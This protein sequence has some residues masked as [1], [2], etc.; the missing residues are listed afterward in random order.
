[1]EPVDSSRRLLRTGRKRSV[2]DG[3]ASSFVRRMT[4]VVHT[5]PFALVSFDSPKT[6]LLRSRN[7]WQRIRLF[8]LMRGVRRIAYAS[9]VGVGGDRNGACQTG[10]RWRRL[11]QSRKSGDDGSHACVSSG[12]GTGSDD[13]RHSWTKWWFREC[14]WIGLRCERFHSGAL[15]WPGDP[16]KRAC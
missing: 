15:G 14:Q 7:R 2:G 16:G 13:G 10:C 4:A 8:P 11:G 6:P 5:H 12:C 9:A 1:M 3:D